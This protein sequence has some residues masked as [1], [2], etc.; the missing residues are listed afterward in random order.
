M[1][2]YFTAM[3]AWVLKGKP[4]IKYRGYNCGCCGAWVE[5]EFEIPTYKSIGSD[6]DT[7]GLCDKCA[8]VE[9][10]CF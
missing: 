7:W 10:P 2:H 6:L 9:E 3:I 4:M 1:I 5:E 8:T